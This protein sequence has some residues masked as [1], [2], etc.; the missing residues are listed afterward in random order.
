MA[1]QLAST[2]SRLTA[3]VPSARP[4]VMSEAEAGGGEGLEAET[5]EEPGGAGIPGIGNDE[6]PRPLVEGAEHRRLLLLNIHHGS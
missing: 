5:G 1:R 6:G 4:S 3:F 2:S